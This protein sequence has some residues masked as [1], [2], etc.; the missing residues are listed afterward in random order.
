M[1]I[2]MLSILVLTVLTS[3]VLVGCKSK[4][5]VK[6]ETIKK[7]DNEKVVTKEE[8][9]KLQKMTDQ[10]ILDMYKKV[11]DKLLELFIKGIDKN[12]TVYDENNNILTELNT[13]YATK[14]ERDNIL[15]SFFSEE[16]SKKYKTYIEHEGKLKLKLNALHIPYGGIKGLKVVEKNFLNDTNLE[17]KIIA[18]YDIDNP[19]DSGYRLLTL[20]ITLD[21]NDIK[22]SSEI[23]NGR[24][25]TLEEIINEIEINR[26][27]MSKENILGLIKE[28][29]ELYDILPDE[30]DNPI[31]SINFLK[32]NTNKTR[33]DKELEVAKKLD[34]EGYEIYR[35][36][37]GDFTDKGYLQNAAIKVTDNGNL[38]VKI[39]FAGHGTYGF[40]L[41]G[42]M[43]K[44]NE[45]E[46]TGVG[47]RTE[48][49]EG[50]SYVIL[51][52][53]EDGTIQIDFANEWRDLNSPTSTDDEIINMFEYE[54]VKNSNENNILNK[55]DSKLNKGKD[56]TIKYN[57]IVE[58]IELL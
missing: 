18:K 1:K 33:E 2:K 7:T 30:N 21:N 57:S 11:D 45:N 16:V 14:E 20:K 41:D 9:N 32:E 28:V 15:D 46:W 19:I 10:E 35:N 29:E 17:A 47:E 44:H 4:G 42:E 51:E 40:S 24:S 38:D 3:S 37:F 31:S 48:I 13:E 8:K 58:I 12:S 39:I 5:V 56:I 26:Q 54:E 25:F 34:E 27:E 6:Q 43:K 50:R 53:K 23:T 55:V 36:T 52:K 49:T 22:F